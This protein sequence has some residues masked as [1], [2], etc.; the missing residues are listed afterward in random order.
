[1]KVR[2]TFD[3]SVISV[4]PSV[5]V[6]MAKSSRIV[7]CRQCKFVDSE[8]K[9]IQHHLR[10]H[11]TAKTI[12]W[13]CPDCDYAINFRGKMWAHRRN[14]HRADPSEDMEES[15]HGTYEDVS[16]SKYTKPTYPKVLRQRRDHSGSGHRP[17]V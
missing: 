4:S 14:V 5:I 8:E 16:S 11:Q 13:A 1:M 10:Q 6:E 3:P 17:A 7:E 9:V 15:C 12:P 2:L